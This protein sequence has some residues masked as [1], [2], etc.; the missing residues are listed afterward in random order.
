MSLPHSAPLQWP[1]RYRVDL[2]AHVV[3][4]FLVLAVPTEHLTNAGD[5]HVMR[6]ELR[7]L[8]AREKELK[9]ELRQLSQHDLEMQTLIA[10]LASGGVLADGK[11]LGA[12]KTDESQRRRLSIPSVEDDEDEGFDETLSCSTNGEDNTTE[13]RREEL[14]AAEEAAMVRLHELADEEWVVEQQVCKKQIAVRTAMMG[15][16]YT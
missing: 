15:K 10:Q 13:R 7:V 14:V 1:P 3:G 5:M 12:T 2:F 6:Q 4:I 11:S 9:S 16:S 8:R